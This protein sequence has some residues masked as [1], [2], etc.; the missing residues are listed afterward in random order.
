LSP[1]LS[2]SVKQFTP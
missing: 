1:L 2:V